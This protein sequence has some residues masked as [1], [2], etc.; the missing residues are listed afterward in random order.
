MKKLAIALLALVLPWAAQ[1]ASPWPEGAEVYIIS[2]QDGAEVTGPVTVVFGL[3][4]MGVAPA[5]T[6]REKTGHHHLLI[7][8]PLPTGE[9]LQY[10]LLLG[11][12]AVVLSNGKAA[13]LTANTLKF[14]PTV[15]SF[16][17][18]VHEVVQLIL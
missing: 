16:I 5:G 3:R 7:N 9:D 8:Y 18:S 14:E 13:F 11:G 17:S 4:G 10:S 6:E 15:S 2:P 12:F 1:A